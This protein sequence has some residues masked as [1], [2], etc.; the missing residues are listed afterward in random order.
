MCVTF[1]LCG[2]RADLWPFYGFLCKRL[3]HCI[4]KT[5]IQPFIFLFIFVDYRNDRFFFF[6]YKSLYFECYATMPMLADDS[7]FELGPSVLTL[8]KNENID[9]STHNIPLQLTLDCT[10]NAI[11]NPTVEPPLLKDNISK[12]DCTINVTKST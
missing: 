8:K 3:S 9:V 5:F 11:K 12:Y 6:P 1:L 10:E 7:Y 4:K 2:P